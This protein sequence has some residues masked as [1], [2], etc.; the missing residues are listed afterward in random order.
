[1]AEKCAVAAPMVD[2]TAPQSNEAADPATNGVDAT[3]VTAP[4]AADK[5]TVQAVA[6]VAAAPIVSPEEAKRDQ[7]VIKARAEKLLLLLKA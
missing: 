2:A 5:D 4:D 3:I 7:E 1:M 6:A